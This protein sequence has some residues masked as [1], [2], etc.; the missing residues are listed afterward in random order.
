M[1]ALDF[2]QELGPNNTDYP[3]TS[4]MVLGVIAKDRCCR[5]FAEW[6]PSFNPKEHREMLDRQWRLQQEEKT[7]DAA[8]K[9]EDDRDMRAERRHV[10][11]NV[12]FGITVVITTI[13]GAM[14]GA[15][16]FSKPW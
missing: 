9:R 11:S 12:I 2:R 3:Y 8:L 4:S 15:G 1:R 5:E 6:Q 13:L 7:R 10:Q 16:W 14:I